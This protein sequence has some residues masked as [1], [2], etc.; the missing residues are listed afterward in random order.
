MLGRHLSLVN[1]KGRPLPLRRA[2]F[3]QETRIGQGKVRFQ[4]VM[5]KLKEVG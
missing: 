1:L 3:G 5:R 2:R 4:E